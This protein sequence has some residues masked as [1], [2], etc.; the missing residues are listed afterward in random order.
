MC[1]KLYLI[2]IVQDTFTFR[3]YMHNFYVYVTGKS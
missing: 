3:I 2:A 1:H